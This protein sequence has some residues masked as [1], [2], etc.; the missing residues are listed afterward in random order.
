MLLLD[1]HALVWLAS[2]QTRLSQNA[3]A[4]IRSSAGAIHVSSVSAWELAVLVKTRRLKLP[5]APADFVD[6]AITHHG[7]HEIP[8][9]R[10]LALAAIALPDLHADSVDRVLVATARAFGMRLLSMDQTIAS[11]PGIQVVW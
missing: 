5:L 4:A 2:D 8:V 7:L 1:T 6:R 3:R 9:D 11:Y 10:H